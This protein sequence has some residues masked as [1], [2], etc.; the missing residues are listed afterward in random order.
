MAIRP[1]QSS[2]WRQLQLVGLKGPKGPNPT[3]QQLALY[4]IL[5]FRP[6]VSTLPCMQHSLKGSAIRYAHGNLLNRSAPIWN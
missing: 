4:L 5:I 3:H 2:V 1:N 6:K